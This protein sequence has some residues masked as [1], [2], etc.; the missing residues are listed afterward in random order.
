MSWWTLETH[1]TYTLNQINAE[2]RLRLLQKPHVCIATLANE[3][4]SRLLVMKK[5]C[6]AP[7]E[8]NSQRTRR[9]FGQW[10]LQNGVQR[11]ELIFI[12]EAG[13]NLY[14]ARTRGRARV[15]ER[16]VRVV[17]G[18]REPNLT[19]CFAISNTQGLVH[20][21]IQ[22]GGMTGPVFVEY[23]EAVS[24][25]VALN[26]AFIYDNA[27]A[28]RRGNGPNGPQILPLQDLRPFAA[29]LANVEHRRKRNLRV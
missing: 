19:L 27:P 20:Y 17:N 13:I 6:N 23:L 8:R 7:A 16:T 24:A 3:L 29:L 15:A 12:D 4:K 9:D 1:S 5:L 10:L 25:M 2:L 26:S 18:R 11:E 28:H 14:V 22:E 21:T